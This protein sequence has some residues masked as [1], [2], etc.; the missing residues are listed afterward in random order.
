MNLK[1]NIYVK[2]LPRANPAYGLGT[3]TSPVL[4][5]LKLKL[6][7]HAVYLSLDMN[8]SDILTVL[9]YHFTFY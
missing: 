6:L 1:K 4:R 5:N 7:L 8:K 3:F 9:L 2:P